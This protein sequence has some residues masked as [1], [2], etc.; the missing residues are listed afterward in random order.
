MGEKTEKLLSTLK[1]QPVVPVLIVDDAKSAVPLARALVAGGL[2]AI[3]ITMRTPAALE[4]VRAVA[5]EV[6]GAEVG[7]GTILNVAHWEAAV[8]AGSKFIVSPG[9]TQELL[10][11]AA[12]SDVPL[13]PG[14]ATASEVMALRE[15]GYQV[16]KF[17]PAEQAGGA[18]Y[19]KALSSPLAG[20]LFCPT[21]GISLKNAH[22]Y[23]SLPNVICVG[24]SWVAPK[25][26]VAA[27]DWAGITKLAAEA[28]ALK[29]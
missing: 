11:A 4:A 2:K 6:E 19:L 3:E 27:G 26:L 17:F 20:T 23:L 1:L 16:L 14:A 29:A 21:G 5:A 12:D 13:L 7:A 15:E 22:D 9:T 24:G 18:A 10:D 28:A 8:A 25:E